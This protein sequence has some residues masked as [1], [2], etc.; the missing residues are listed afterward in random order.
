MRFIIHF[1]NITVCS[2]HKVTTTGNIP[3]IERYASKRIHDIYERSRAE[4]TPF[5]ILSG[6]YGLLNP[7]DKIP[8]YDKKLTSE[9]LD[10]MM[11]IVRQQLISEKP[12]EIVFHI[13]TPF[14]FKDWSAAPNSLE[15]PYITLI[16]QLCGELRITLR[17]V[18]IK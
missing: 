18:I 14:G 1:M 12:K 16:E 3:A 2:K 13:R 11:N 5:R 17:K 10:E 6:K 9:R 7:D 4:D 8:F 15:Q